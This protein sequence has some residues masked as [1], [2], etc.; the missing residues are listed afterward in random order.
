MLCWVVGVVETS[1]CTMLYAH[2]VGI[3]PIFPIFYAFFLT[4]I[5]IHWGVSN[6]KKNASFVEKKRFFWLHQFKISQKMG[7]QD[8]PI[9]ISGSVQKLQGHQVVLF[10]HQWEEVWINCGKNCE[11]IDCGRKAEY[12]VLCL[13]QMGCVVW[14]PPKCEPF[15]CDGFNWER[16]RRWHWR[17]WRRR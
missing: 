11:R 4:V 7:L 9:S 3:F 14:V 8:M 6:M 13:P 10:G 5:T 1:H 16:Q 12:N 2:L 15:I 17:W